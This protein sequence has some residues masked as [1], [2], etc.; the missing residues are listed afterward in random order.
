MFSYLIVFAR[1][2]IFIVINTFSTTFTSDLDFLAR[3]GSKVQSYAFCVSK[4]YG[5]AT[6]NTP[7]ARKASGNP[8]LISNPLEKS[9]FSARLKIECTMQLCT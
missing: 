3:L 1:Y 7:L 9:Q 8:L 2:D 5:V 4:G 6:M